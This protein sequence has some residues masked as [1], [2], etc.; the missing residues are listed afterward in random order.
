M[1]TLCVPSMNLVFYIRYNSAHNL[2][3]LLFQGED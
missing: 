1:S 3:V 2:P